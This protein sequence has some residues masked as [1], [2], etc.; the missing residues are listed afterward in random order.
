MKIKQKTIFL[1]SE[2][3]A[4][5]F[6]NTKK[7]QDR[8]FN[9][10][11]PILKIL[12]K[13]LFKKKNKNLLEIG[14]GEGKI[15]DWISRNMNINCY[16]IDPSAKAI[17]VAKKLKIKAYKRTADKLLFKNEKFDYIIFGF[18]LYL[19][20]REDLFQIACEANRVLKP[21]GIIIIYDF[22]SKKPIVKKYHHYQGLYSYKMDYKKMFEWHPNFSLI[23]HEVKAYCSK[24]ISN[25]KKDFLGISALKKRNF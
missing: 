1:K 11:H 12:K 25:N 23:H 4:F 5:F 6:R 24:K 19:C 8:N 14:C 20:D 18:C 10:N 16:G 7:I 9:Y 22:F 17:K 2:G 21:G 13:N 15:L 3:D